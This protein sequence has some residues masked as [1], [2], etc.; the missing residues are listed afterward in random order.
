MKAITLFQYYILSL[1]V[2]KL[3]NYEEET[4]DKDC[5]RF[6]HNGADAKRGNKSSQRV[7]NVFI[8]RIKAN[9]RRSSYYNGYTA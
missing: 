7:W 2:T 4:K 1:P 8:G 9:S 3:F 5:T 6:R